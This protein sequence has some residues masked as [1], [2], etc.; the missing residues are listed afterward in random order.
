M[1]ITII[2]HARDQMRER[3]ISEAQVRAVLGHPYHEEP[4]HACTEG[5]VYVGH[6]VEEDGKE[7]EVFEAV[8]CKRCEGTDILK[9]S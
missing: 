4:P 5:A 2:P 8:R 3:G 1:R 9:R 6:L 7:V